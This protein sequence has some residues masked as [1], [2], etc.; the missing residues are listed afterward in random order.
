MRVCTY[1]EPHLRHSRALDFSV[2]LIR[3]PITEFTPKFPVLFFSSIPFLRGNLSHED[4]EGKALM[5]W[6]LFA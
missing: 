2:V 3:Q 6:A 4:R 1:R 5:N